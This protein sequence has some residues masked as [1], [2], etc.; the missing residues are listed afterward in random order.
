MFHLDNKSKAHPMDRKH[1]YDDQI[2]EFKKNGKPSLAVGIFDVMLFTEQKEIIL[3]KRSHKKRHN[4]YLIDKTVGGH[5]QYGDSPFYTA[6]IECVQELRVPAV[7]LRQEEDFE[8]TFGILSKSLES[9]AILELI[10]QNI[11]NIANI[12]DGEE[13]EIAKNIW[14]FIG[15]YGGAMKPVDREASGVLY[16]ELDILEEEMKRMPELF[17]PDLHFMI[18]KYRKNIDSLL[19]KLG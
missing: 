13:I 10:D 3:Q 16:Y 9:T 12:Y 15:V 2:E 8:R 11:Y 14:M 6:M 18:K 19:D 5:I 4:A 7:V 17:T 1:F